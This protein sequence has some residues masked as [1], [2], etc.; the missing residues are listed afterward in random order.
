MQRLWASKLWLL[1]YTRTCGTDSCPTG[2]T[3][4]RT[5][6]R[7]AASAYQWPMPFGHMNAHNGE[8]PYVCTSCGKGLSV[9]SALRRHERTHQAPNTSFAARSG[10]HQHVQ[11]R[12]KVQGR[13]PSQLHIEPALNTK[14]KSHLHCRDRKRSNPCI[15]GCALD[16]AADYV[17]PFNKN[18]PG[19]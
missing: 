10:K 2:H 19:G 3:R 8:K 17:K 12:D 13:A 9:A 5:C 7:H 1:G 11:P 6:A 14:H 15:C 16:C 4:S 18:T